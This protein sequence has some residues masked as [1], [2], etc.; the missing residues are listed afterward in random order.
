MPSTWQDVWQKSQLD[1]LPSH[2]SRN[3]YR[4][5]YAAASGGGASGASV[6]MSV[7]TMHLSPQ[8]HQKLSA[9]PILP[10]ILG[11]PPGDK[12]RPDQRPAQSGLLQDCQYFFRENHEQGVQHTRSFSTAP[13]QSR[14][15]CQETPTWRR[16]ILGLRVL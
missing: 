5:I 11:L 4:P 6:T 2:N 1:V 12:M 15:L 9:L 7:W 10:W 13:G 16:G 3:T 8:S 14:R